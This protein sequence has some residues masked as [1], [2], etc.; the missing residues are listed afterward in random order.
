M[1]ADFENA[2]LRESSSS[3]EGYADLGTPEIAT[4][5]DTTIGFEAKTGET[6]DTASKTRKLITKEDRLG[7]PATK[8]K[9]NLPS[10][11]KRNVSH[12]PRSSTT[13]ATKR[14]SQEI[15]PKEKESDYDAATGGEQTAMRTLISP[16]DS[17]QS[18]LQ[19]MF[20]S[21]PD[22][23]ASK[24]TRT[25]GQFFKTRSSSVGSLA[26]KVGV[27]TEQYLSLK[28]TAGEKGIASMKLEGNPIDNGRGKT[29]DRVLVAKDRGDGNIQV[30][31]TNQ[32]ITDKGSFGTILGCETLEGKGPDLVVKCPKDIERGKFKG[33]CDASHE[34][35]KGSELVMEWAFTE[36]GEG[37]F[38]AVGVKAESDLGA[39]L[40]GFLAE[41]Q[42]APKRETLKL[43]LQLTEG[44]AHLFRNGNNWQDA[45][46]TNVLLTR[47]PDTGE[48]NIVL[49]DF[50]ELAK[51]DEIDEDS[52]FLEGDPQY[53][54]LKFTDSKER[55]D[56]KV[57][58]DTKV[59][60]K[61]DLESNKTNRKES[62]ETLANVKMQHDA[63]LRVI[64]NKALFKNKDAFTRE[65]NDI[66]TAM[67]GDMSFETFKGFKDN[68]TPLED[69]IKQLETNM[70]GLKK[71]IQEYDQLIKEPVS[72]LSKSRVQ[73]LA[74]QK[75]MYANGFVLYEIFSGGKL[76]YP[77]YAPI[78]TV[79][80]KPIKHKEADPEAPFDRKT[81]ED[82][83]VPSDLID[84][85]E[86][87]V[88]HDPSKRPSNEQFLYAYNEFKN[89]TPW[90]RRR[91][92]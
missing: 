33:E 83:D 19:K 27:S 58:Q 67:D 50:G 12:K 71:S 32:F 53:Q 68:K 86:A 88:D 92:K 31:V 44:M 8:R 2:P 41:E 72:G 81:L 13:T 46:N 77:K 76:P 90:M 38:Y 25:E 34:I 69:A 48:R 55:E 45:A 56:L 24:L 7:S 20:H 57:A 14:L 39:Y 17:R 10:L 70:D 21:S 35:A 60:W 79:T 64:G 85:I 18:D 89:P 37:D 52:F 61:R 47:D 73:E 82:R 75:N 43:G 16:G 54:S 11:K 5:T 65:Y 84:L 6:D 30:V 22:S 36:S 80:G 87:M 63:L 4:S 78:S 1:S 40:N 59:V 15:L 23:A 49:T 91:V 9:G 51:F 3:V 26:K 28:E 74:Q 62:I 29:Y 66:K 42:Q